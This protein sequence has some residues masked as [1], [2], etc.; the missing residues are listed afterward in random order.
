MWG[1]PG[2]QQ[3]LRRLAVT[4]EIDNV[5][6]DVTIQGD[7]IYAASWAGGLQRFRF[8]NIPPSDG[9]DPNP[10]EPIPLPMDGELDQ[11]C[12][13][14]D[15]E[16][17][18]LNPKD[19]QDG[20][21]HNHKGFSVHAVEDTLWVGTAGGINKGVLQPN[22]CINWRHFNSFRDGISG[23]WVIGITHQELTDPGGNPYMRIWAITWSTGGNESYGLSYTDDGGYTW[24]IIEQL[25]SLNLRIYGISTSSEKVVVASEN[26]LFISFDG[27]HWEKL[28]NPVESGGEQLLTEAYFSCLL[29]P[30]T[31]RTWVGTSDGMA[32]TENLGEDWEVIRFWNS[33]SNQVDEADRFYAYPNPIYTGSYNRLNENSYVRFVFDQSGSINAKLPIFDFSMTKVATLAQPYEVDNEMEVLWNCKNDWGDVVA[34]G[35]YF[36]RLETSTNTQWTKVV[37][38]ND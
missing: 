4:T 1:E 9:S 38:I 14:I 33:T 20:G 27:S 19:P 26:G 15:P 24:H 6:Y 10:W 16:E 7:Y 12:G 18:E 17:F 30:G 25:T 5:S 22:G 29:E 32:F 3:E 21:S 28:N 31:S 8:K 37:V 34:N 36:C 23:N 11:Y 35:V 13:W 2:F